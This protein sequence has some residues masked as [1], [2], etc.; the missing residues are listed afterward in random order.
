M[1]IAGGCVAAALPT[2]AV[3]IALGWVVSDASEQDIVSVFPF[4]ALLVVGV[5]AWFDQRIWPPARP[6]RQGIIAV[7][8][9]LAVGLGLTVLLM[10]AAVGLGKE[11]PDETKVLPLPKNLTLVSR[12]EGCG[13]EACGVTYT[14]ATPDSVPTGEL[15]ARLWL[16]LEGR[17]WQRQ[18]TNAS[19]R[20]IGWLRP[21]HQCLYVRQDNPEVVTLD[22]ST[23]L[24]LPP[25]N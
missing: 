4:L 17:G 8:V 19:C 11:R 21:V 23:V 15:N 24:D 12:D 13:S 18:R 10:A 1:W 7:R 2:S 9:L 14:L 5:L 25:A 22:L 6:L 16:H 3:A 20:D